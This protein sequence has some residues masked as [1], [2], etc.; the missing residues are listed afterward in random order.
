MWNVDSTCMLWQMVLH[1]LS[2]LVCK[3][4]VAQRTDQSSGGLKYCLQMF[5]SFGEIFGTLAVALMP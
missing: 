4:K 2:R 3:G 5:K 1:Q